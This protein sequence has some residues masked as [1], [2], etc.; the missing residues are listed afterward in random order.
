MFAANAVGFWGPQIRRG[1]VVRWPYLGVP[2]APIDE[3]DIAAVGVRALCE[4]GHAGAEYVLT[5]P[6]SLTQREQIATIGEAIGRRLDIQ[7]I[8][9]EDAVRELTPVLSAPVAK[10]LTNAWSAAAGLPAFVSPMFE[11]IMG[12][13][14]RRFAEWAAD[15]VTGFR[16]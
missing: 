4:D 1:D 6:E 3:R 9:P 13:P 12:R 7:E 5:G 11:K 15:H 14:P 8:P 16:G 10:M 2:T